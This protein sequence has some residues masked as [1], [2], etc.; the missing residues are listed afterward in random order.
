MARSSFRCAVLALA[1][2]GLNA[3]AAPTA[4]LVS[5]VVSFPAE[6]DFVQGSFV[7]DGKAQEKLAG[8]AQA[9]QG[10]DLEVLVVRAFAGPL[11]TPLLAL[12][13]ARSVRAFFV[14]HGVA[15]ERVYIESRSDEARPHRFELDVVA[16][17]KR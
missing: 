12:E 6:A 17:R 4:P 2:L 3:G 11:D 1:L 7:L 16:Q 14:L 15:P 9:L 8:V 13:R 5:E 10:V